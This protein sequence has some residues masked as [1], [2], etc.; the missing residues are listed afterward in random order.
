MKNKIR[1]ASF[2][3]SLAL[4]GATLAAGGGPITSEQVA[5]RGVMTSAIATGEL[6]ELDGAFVFVPREITNATLRQLRATTTFSALLAPA[7]VSFPCSISGVFSARITQQ[8][9]IVLKLDWSGCTSSEFGSRVTRNG[10]AEFVW[11]GNSL[12]PSA[13]AS[14]RLGA[15]DRDFVESNRPETPRPYFDG[16]TVY[17]NQRVTGVLPVVLE[18]E[19]AGYFLGRYLVETK[20]FMRRVQRLP[21]FNS[22]GEPSAEFYDYEY[23]VSTDAAVLTGNYAV[24]GLNNVMEWGIVAGKVVGRYTYPA[25]PL[26]PN[27]KVL[28]K[29]YRGT[30]MNVRRNYDNTL[31]KYLFSVDGKIEGDFN[32][33]WNLGCS[34]ADTFTYRTRKA[35][36]Q[37]PYS[38]FVELY[39]AGELVINGNTV[40]TFT[41][42]GTEPYVDLTGHA[43]VKVQ[44][45]GTFNYDY[46]ESILLGPVFE[47]AR[48][49]P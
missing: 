36:A 21:E 1:G 15:V 31:G 8:R 49:T 44:G 45:V 29:W 35:L 26:H 48:C 37:S 27:V 14:I 19:D 32:A 39:D 34:G 33:F 18:D 12:S 11:A 4:S 9:P 20:G 24:D 5:A 41:A 25:R 6:G 2:L 28:D 43:S 3:I 38:W 13:V 10:P 46:P 47:A 23:R 42:T 22:A 30:G 40:A 16:Q 17:R 7:G